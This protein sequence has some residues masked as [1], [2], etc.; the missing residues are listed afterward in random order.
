MNILLVSLIV[1]TM[2]IR[3]QHE[4]ESAETGEDVSEEA[5]ASNEVV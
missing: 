1:W 2:G 3:Q 4:L 5:E